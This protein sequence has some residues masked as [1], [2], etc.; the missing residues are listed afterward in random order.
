MHQH[1]NIKLRS[2]HPKA[3]A[4]LILHFHPLIG[5]R[6]LWV[7][8]ILSTQHHNKRSKKARAELTLPNQCAVESANV[9]AIKSASVAH[10][11]QSNKSQG[12]SQERTRAS[13]RSQC[14]R[15]SQWRM[16]IWE[17]VAKSNSNC[18]SKWELKLVDIGLAL[19]PYIQR[20]SS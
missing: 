1:F 10:G 12:K 20:K 19:G 14:S 13:R 11:R 8:I 9:V 6:C 3:S 4:I 15:K 18:N 5:V 2:A 7:D 16:N 17:R